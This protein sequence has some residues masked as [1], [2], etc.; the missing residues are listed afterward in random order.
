M[1]DEKHKIQ[2]PPNIPHLLKNS[3]LIARIWNF[4]D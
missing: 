2:T 3:E 1:S 4:K